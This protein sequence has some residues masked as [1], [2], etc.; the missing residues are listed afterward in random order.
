MVAFPVML[1]MPPSVA[2]LWTVMAEALLV[3]LIRRRPAETVVAPLWV[4]GPD[5]VSVPVPTLVK[6]VGPVPLLSS[7]AYS[8]SS[9]RAPT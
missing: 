5:R 3:P 7:P 9:L 6:A 2:P 8:P 4:H 1:P